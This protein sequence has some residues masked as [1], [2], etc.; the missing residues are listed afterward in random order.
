MKIP[1]FVYVHHKKLYSS[2]IYIQF[3]FSLS[4]ELSSKLRQL[5]K[6]I[7]H[8]IIIGCLDLVVNVLLFLNRYDKFLV[9]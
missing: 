1:V 6:S 8:K 2:T 5:L 7:L 3:V 9:L 4:M